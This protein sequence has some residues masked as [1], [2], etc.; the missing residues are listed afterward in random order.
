M[1]LLEKAG[2]IDAF[3]SS[4][5]IADALEDLATS[6]KCRETMNKSSVVWNFSYLAGFDVDGRG[7]TF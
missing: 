3:Y 6:S 7:S 2:R 4:G 5:V 1:S